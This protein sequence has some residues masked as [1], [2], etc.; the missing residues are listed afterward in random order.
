MPEDSLIHP[1]AGPER[2]GAKAISGGGY[3]SGFFARV[4]GSLPR[5]AGSSGL[6]PARRFFVAAPRHLPISLSCVMGLRHALLRRR[7]CVAVTSKGSALEGD[8]V[9]M[10]EYVQISR[11]GISRPPG[12]CSRSVPTRRSVAAPGSRSVS[13]GPRARRARSRGRVADTAGR[14]RTACS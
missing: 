8:H 6:S 2:L 5:P 9:S 10:G 12:T 14:R 4:V 13:C 3:R 7:L 11:P 1:G